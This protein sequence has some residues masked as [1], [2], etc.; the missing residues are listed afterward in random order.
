MMELGKKVELYHRLE[1]I[2]NAENKEKDR[3][4]Y[5]VQAWEFRLT[6]AVSDG[7]GYFEHR[8]KRLSVCLWQDGRFRINP[9]PK[10]WWS[11]CLRGALWIGLIYAL[12]LVDYPWLA[13]T[14]VG[15]GMAYYHLGKWAEKQYLL[16]EEIKQLTEWHLTDS[17]R[18]AGRC[19]GDTDPF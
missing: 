13:Y 14:L 16:R 12:S 2:L 17:E 11:K 6:D 15:A 1:E 8:W 5:D 9:P 19:S 7:E 10:P 3:R 18:L 4:L